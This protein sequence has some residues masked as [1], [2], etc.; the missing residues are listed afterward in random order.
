MND[1]YLGK[2]SKIANPRNISF[3]NRA[4]QKYGSPVIREF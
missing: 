2:E 1:D 3:I 4:E